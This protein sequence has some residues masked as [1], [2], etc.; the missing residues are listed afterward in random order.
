MKITL[1]EKECP[2][3]GLVKKADG[4]YRDSKRSSGLQVYCKECQF[5]SNGKRKE[6]A[7]KR[8]ELAARGLKDCTKCKEV[9][10]VGEFFKASN[11]DGLASRCKV[12]TKEADPRKARDGRLRHFYNI[13]I[14]QYESLLDAQDGV[15]AGCLRPP[16]KSKDGVLC[17]DHD[18]TCC[19]G[20]KSCGKCVR[21]LLCDECN[22]SL[23]KL[24]DSRETLLRL[25]EYISA[26]QEPADVCVP[27]RHIW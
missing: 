26:G 16:A 21:G 13:T 8:A 18:H 11:S 1:S 6:L 19:P 25:A 10:P 24:Q 14:E 4:F 12:C 3:C 23:G 7:A 5:R 22:T 9:K 17:V 27:S 15:C 2:K 20:N